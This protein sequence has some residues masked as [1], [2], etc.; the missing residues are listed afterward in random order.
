MIFQYYKYGTFETA[1]KKKTIRLSDITKSND[2]A[3]LTYIAQFI[4]P[5]FRK[6][7]S[8][9]TT[10]K[11]KKYDSNFFEYALDH[12]LKDWF[13]E[14][15]RYYT[16]YVSCFSGAP[17]MLSQW[18]GYGDDGKGVSI[19]FDEA[20]LLSLNPEGSPV[21]D[22]KKVQYWQ[23]SQKARVREA[24]ENF[25]KQLK[26]II[27]EADKLDSTVVDKDK[28]I[29]DKSVNCYHT[30]FYKLFQLGT[31]FK[32]PFFKEEKEIR[33][34]LLQTKNGDDFN[35]LLAHGAKF[36][37]HGVNPGGRGQK[38]VDINFSSCDFNPFKLVTLGP[39]CE[40]TISDVEN[41]LTNNG[42]TGC[43]IVASEGTYR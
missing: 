30:T 26:K 17:D 19:G 27:D 14:E 16:Q 3:E 28:Y 20:E 25:L 9:D 6:V 40:K 13:T 36:G 5:I 4:D 23:R 39:K 41:F 18:R 38:F 15:H 21:L 8:S 2:S 12:E 22:L 10:K 32:S 37:E 7:Y 35:I 24:A 33:L 42:V 1:I 31:Y 43:K 11:L 29:K 34:S